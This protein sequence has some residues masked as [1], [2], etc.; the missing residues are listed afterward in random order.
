MTCET[1]QTQLCALTDGELS[2]FSARRVCRHLDA[3]PSCAAA[4][5][6]V[7]TLTTRAR[8]LPERPAPSP[9]LEA[10]IA[11][12]LPPVLPRKP[13]P[14]PRW[15]PALAAALTAAALAAALLLP[16]SPTRPLPAFADVETAMSRVKYVSW[17]MTTHFYRGHE[18]KNE[19]PLKAAFWVRRSPPAFAIKTE[20]WPIGA[21]WRLFDKR[22]SFTRTPRLEH[23]GISYNEP[24]PIAQRVTQTI[25]GLTEM[26][27]DANSS[28]K[29]DRWAMHAT[30]TP[31]RKREETLTGKSVMRFDRL[32]TTP[33]HLSQGENA[34]ERI[35]MLGQRDTQT[36][37]VDAKTL[38]VVRTER[39]LLAQ[40]GFPRAVT[41]LTNFRYDEPP[42]AGVFDWS[43]PKG[44]KVTVSGTPQKK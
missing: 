10:R 13:T 43:P 18:R 29:A 39:R 9:T 11:A 30:A 3:C 23:Y 31:W 34:K 40:D 1:V 26:P 42:P 14:K 41:V 28:L 7:Q 24:R 6:A 8:A 12:A 32:V 27:T 2:S 44:A 17:T 20:N 38:H 5:A 15:Q 16:G 25:R 19:H 22:G 37:W 33:G 4:S 35:F 21:S 36:I